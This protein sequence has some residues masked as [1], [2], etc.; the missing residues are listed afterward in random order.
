M[1][2][3]QDVHAALINA[4]SEWLD[5]QRLQAMTLLALAIGLIWCHVLLAG[6]ISEYRQQAGTLE[7]E[8]LEK[9]SIVRDISWP[10]KAESA[11]ALVNESERLFWVANSEGEA[12]AKVRD[13]VRL[14]S[15]TVGLDIDRINVDILPLDA[16]GYHR[17]HVDMRGSYEAGKWH[18]FV[19][20]VVAARP[21]MIIESEQLDLRRT[22]GRYRVGV[23]AWVRLGDSGAGVPGE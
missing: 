15:R 13:H 20:G 2:I 10:E 16:R 17:V 4:K 1:A 14:V 21:T 3:K 12:Q 22:P 19:N 6:V 9:Q 7:A 18:D 11:G 8:L 23:I 5:N